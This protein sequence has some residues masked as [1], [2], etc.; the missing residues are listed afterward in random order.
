MR[1]L[2]AT[3]LNIERTLR[4]SLDSLV[5]CALTELNEV[6]EYHGLG[7][8]AGM[9]LGKMLYFKRGERIQSSTA[10]NPE[11]YWTRW[12]TLVSIT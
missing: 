5:K 7:V 6:H 1:E 9:I 3:A 12:I 4:I 11:Q 2:G 10:N 8:G